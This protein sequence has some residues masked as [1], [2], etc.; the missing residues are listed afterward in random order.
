MAGLSRACRLE[1]C[2]TAGLKPALRIVFAHNAD[3]EGGAQIGERNIVFDVHHYLFAFP[4]SVSIE[5]LYTRTLSLHFSI[6]SS[7]FSM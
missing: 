6:I 5:T 2:D 1:I 7:P 4:V 3:F